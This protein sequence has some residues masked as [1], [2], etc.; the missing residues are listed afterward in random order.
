MKRKEKY[1]FRLF[2]SLS[3]TIKEQKK[4]RIT[5][6]RIIIWSAVNK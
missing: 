1:I 5:E 4:N 2:Q 3:T 6:K